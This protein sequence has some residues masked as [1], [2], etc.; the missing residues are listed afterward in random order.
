MITL[1]SCLKSGT[2]STT[3]TP[4]IT[5]LSIIDMA[6]QAPPLE[7]Y[8][9]ATKVSAAIAPG[10]WSQAY[11]AVQPGSYA[12]VFKKAT[13]DSVVASI[14]TASYD[15]AKYYSFIIYND[16]P[17]SAKA[18]TAYDD[19]T[20]ITYDK[21]YVR[22]LH[23]SQDAGQV[24]FYLGATK[25]FNS[26]QLADNQN[27]TIYNNFTGTPPGTYTLQAKV[28]GTD[29][30]I[31]SN[32]FSFMAGNAYTIF[33]GGLKNGTGSNALSINVLMASK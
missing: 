7:T 30:V 8:F 2:T 19:F 10:S 12:V 29:S 18:F 33:L 14:P 5:Y 22:F 3:T 28:A 25:L 27:V 23:L 11:S 16:Q 17:N 21:P 20:G 6:L 9:N 24:D 13:A 26:R 1:T 31:A 32:S 4:P 15:S